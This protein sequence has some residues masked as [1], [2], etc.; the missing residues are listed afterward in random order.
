MRGVRPT[1]PRERKR[2]FTDR[3]SLARFALGLESELEPFADEVDKRFQTW[4]G[5]R[6]NS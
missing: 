6:L 5:G 2:Q 1:R 4:G 3:V